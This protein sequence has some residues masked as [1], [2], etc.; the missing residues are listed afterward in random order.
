MQPTNNDKNIITTVLPLYGLIAEEATI[1]VFGSGLI[2]R[3]W[4]IEYKGE[5]YILQRINTAVFQQPEA[6]AANIDAI[7][8]YLL[9]HR[10]EYLFVQPVK[11]LQGANMVWQNGDCF[12]LF[13]FVKNSHTLDVL[14]RPEQAY[15]AAKQFGRFTRKL[16]GFPLERLKTTLPDFH[17]LLL[18]YQQFELALQNGNPSRIKECRVL[19]EWLLSQEVIARQAAALLQHPEFYRRVTH[20]DTKISNVLF[21]EREKGLCVIDLD[22]VM[23]GYFLS[24]VGDMMRT[25]VSPVNEEEKNMKAIDIRSNYFQALAQG[26]LEEMSTVLTAFERQQFVFAGKYMIYMQALRFLTDYLNNDV[27][28]GAKYETQNKVRAEN[29]ATLLQRLLSCEREL[30]RLL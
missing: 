30:M 8:T 5:A 21:D 7:G 19:I 16:E 1:T 20:H 14:Q 27:Y 12:R 4:K 26:Y 3:T 28:Y 29:Q 23:P 11:T 25:Y 13:P 15:E 22:T 18:R 24:D 17:N 6:I 2:N 9:R 10:P